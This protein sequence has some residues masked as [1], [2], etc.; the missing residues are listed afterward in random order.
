VSYYDPLIGEDIGL[1]MPQ[2]AWCIPSH[3][4]RFPSSADISTIAEVATSG[5][6][7]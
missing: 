7:Q 6:L 5:A 2:R 1:A 4:A 3:P